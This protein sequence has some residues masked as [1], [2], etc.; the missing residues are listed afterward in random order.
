ML[1]HIKNSKFFKKIVSMAN[2]NIFVKGII[3]I[4]GWAIALIPV[5]IYI[6]LNWLIVPVGF[7]QNLALVGLWA[8]GLGALQIYFIVLVA[9]MSFMIIA[10][11][12]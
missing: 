3:I 6:L 5:W 8:L 4:T 9:I 1:S 12:F 10:E 7:W 2:S 11:D